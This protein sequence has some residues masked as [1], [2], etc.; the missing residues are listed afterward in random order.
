ME[1]LTTIFTNIPLPALALFVILGVVL[2]VEVWYLRPKRKL[3]P[4]PS[5]ETPTS[6]Q[7][8]Q[9]FKPLS[10]KQIAIISGLIILLIIIPLS[11]Y[12]FKKTQEAKKVPP[13]PSPT[14]FIPSPTPTRRPLPTLTPTPFF[15]PTPTATVTATPRE[16]IKP[17]PTRTPTPTP[18]KTP[19][20]G[21]PSPTATPLPKVEKPEE[22]PPAASNQQILF[23]VLVG[24]LTLSLGGI[25][26]KAK[27]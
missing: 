9:E 7:P 18:Q 6:P 5:E 17:T 24:L 22:L 4:I 3:P 14:V 12:L 20:V 19:K 25:L 1:T 27:T 8:P 23:L 15:P 16:T 2:G 13:L 11:A 26:L 10:Q 21:A